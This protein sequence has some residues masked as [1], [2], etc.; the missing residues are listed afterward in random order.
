M[1]MLVWCVGFAALL[2]LGY[3]AIARADAFI[4]TH[5]RAFRGARRIVTARRRKPARR[6]ADELQEA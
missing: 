3:W 1:K 6:P 2:A 4:R 5:P